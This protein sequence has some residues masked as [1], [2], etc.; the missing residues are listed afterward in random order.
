MLLGVDNRLGTVATLSA[1]GIQTVYDNL[2]PVT[3]VTWACLVDTSY[4]KYA[5]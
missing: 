4:I 2:G 3:S 5:S 1:N